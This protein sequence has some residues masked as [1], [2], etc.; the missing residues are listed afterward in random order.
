MRRR[1]SRKRPY[2]ASSN[3]PQTR[4]QDYCGAWQQPFESYAE[5]NLAFLNGVIRKYDPNGLFQ[6]AC[7]GGFKLN[8]ARGDK[9]G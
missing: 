4:E 2:N 1:K 9:M 3:L 7:V 5:D 6:D 8:I